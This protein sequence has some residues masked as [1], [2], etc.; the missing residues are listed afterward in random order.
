M[1]QGEQSVPIPPQAQTQTQP[2]T[3]SNIPDLRPPEPTGIKSVDEENYDNYL[4]FLQIYKPDP[5]VDEDD[6]NVITPPTQ[7][8]K[9]VEIIES[10]D[11]VPT[12]P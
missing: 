8:T 10:D 12:E 7:P 2:T 1:I 5:F 9:A 11:V 6:N 3:T 4:K